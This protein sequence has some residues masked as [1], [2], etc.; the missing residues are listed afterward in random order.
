M[1]YDG[2]LATLRATFTGNPEIT[3]IDHGTGEQ[4]AIEFDDSTGLGHG[5][6]DVGL[7]S[8]F[9]NWL[10]AGAPTDGATLSSDARSSLVS[11]RVAWA[12]ERAR[13]TGQ[14]VAMVDR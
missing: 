11:H 13:T 9:A 8:A 4:H 10:D 14:V 5:G 1:R 12:A 6:G 2:T 3:V 7:L